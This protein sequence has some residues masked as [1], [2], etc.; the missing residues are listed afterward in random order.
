[1]KNTIKFSA[2]FI[3]L[4]AAIFTFNTNSSAQTKKEILIVADQKASCRGIVAQDCL[5]VKRLD[6]EKF[7]LF[8]QNIE[9]FKFI[10]GYFYVLDVR[11]DNVRNAPADASNIKYRLLRVLA[12]VKAENNPTAMTQNLSGVEW[13]LTRVEGNP[14]ESEK[15][16][17]R[18]DE[19]NNRVNGSGGCNSFGGKLTKNGN[20]IKIGQVISTK[21]ACVNR[22]T[23]QVEND[24]FRNLER[25][26]K[27]EISGNKL[28]LTAGDAT[29]LE[30]EA[31][32]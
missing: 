17:I 10:P 2:V 23:M 9:N 19:Q 31:K 12:R 22:D 25:V 4:F 24:F 29:V 11:V 13:K 3:F 28:M 18:F 21:M 30:F 1:M 26:T 15:A 16:A 8:R 6:E 14:V 5:Q 7:E 32:K 20:E 27:Y